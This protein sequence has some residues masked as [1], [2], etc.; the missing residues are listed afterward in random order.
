MIVMRGVALVVMTALL[1]LTGCSAHAHRGLTVVTSFYPLQWVTQQIAGDHAS[2]S[3]LT[4]PG[5]EPH[6]LELTVRQTA[7]L[8][9]ADIVVYE[10]GL[11]PA[12]DD[13]IDTTD[14]RHV[15]DAMSVVATEQ[16][17]GTTDPHVWL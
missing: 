11:Q 4:S 1:P 2:V 9:D 6:D 3:T 12:V 15:V 14:P 7:D 16:R 10:K 13:A 8:E 5:R 17:D